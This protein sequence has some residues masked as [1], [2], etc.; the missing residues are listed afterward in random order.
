MLGNWGLDREVLGT[1]QDDLGMVTSFTFLLLFL[2][3]NGYRIL[4]DG[5]VFLSFLI[6]FSIVHKALVSHD[7]LFWLITFV[8]A[9]MARVC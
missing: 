1:I 8:R 2:A 5:I 6:A 9:F 3:L 7:G 4:D